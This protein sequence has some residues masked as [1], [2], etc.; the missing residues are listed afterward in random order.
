MSTVVPCIR[1]DEIGT[2][3][4]LLREILAEAS[5]AAGRDL[6]EN[7]L[8]LCDHNTFLLATWADEGAREAGAKYVTKAWTKRTDDA[9]YLHFVP[10]WEYLEYEDIDDILG[11]D[12]QT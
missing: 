9:P 10:C 5:Q 12:I 7:I 4:A 2:A 11:H 8:T 6:G 3:N 1:S